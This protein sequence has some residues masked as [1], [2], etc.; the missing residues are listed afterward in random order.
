MDFFTTY[1]YQ[2]FFN[3]LV[4][5]YWLVGQVLPE[6][7]MGI[8]VIL[9]AVAVRIILLPV[10]LIGEQSEEEKFKIAQRIKQIKRDFASDPIRLKAETRAVMHQSPGAIVSEV[11][12]VVIQ[13]VIIL[14]L[15]R[16]FAT[17][18]EGEDLHLIYPFMPSIPLPI[19]LLFLGKYDLS[20]TNSTLNLL[21][22]A[23]IALSE[24]IHLY[25]Q[26][27]RPS[28]RDFISLVIIFPVVCFLV[29][30]FLPS[31]KKVFI[32]TSLA[33]GVVVALVKQALF[34][35][36]SMHHKPVAEQGAAENA[37]PPLQK[38]I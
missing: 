6:P 22:T 8:A 21:Q 15:Y 16:I 24:F 28:R 30:V 20:H 5:L 14:I 23:M 4:G 38:T 37:P 31:G 1:I 25:F 3:I 32:I 9:F 11:F 26:P 33:F 10:D 35:Y 18:L 2:P 27:V 29:F 17:G 12:N 36:Y 7:D 34:L 13:L 19:N